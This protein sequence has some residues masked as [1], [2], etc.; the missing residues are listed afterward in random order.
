MTL[1]F[2]HR[3]IFTHCHESIIQ[4]ILAPYIQ[5]VLTHEGSTTRLVLEFFDST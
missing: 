5:E 2:I 1:L 3:V 4:C